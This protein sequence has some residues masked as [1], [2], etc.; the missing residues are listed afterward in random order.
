[1]N[2]TYLVEVQ[3]ISNNEIVKSLSV[4]GKNKADK[5]AR[6]IEINLH[7]EFIVTVIKSTNA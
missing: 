4:I 6:G 5:V 2:Y 7:P 1:M 3:S